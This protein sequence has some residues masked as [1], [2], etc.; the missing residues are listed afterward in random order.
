MQVS[1][2]AYHFALSIFPSLYFALEPCVRVASARDQYTVSYL[3]IRPPFWASLPDDPNFYPSSHNSNIIPSLI[4]LDIMSSCCCS[5]VRT[6]YTPTV[7]FKE[8]PCTIYTLTEAHK[9]LIQL[10]RCSSCSHRLIGPDPRALHLFNFNNRI[11]LTHELLDEYTSAYTSSET[12]FVAWVTVLSR[13]Y[14]QRQS[15]RPFLS[16]DLFRTI[17]FAYVRLQHLESKDDCPECGPIPNDTIWDGITLAFSQK[18][19]LPSLCPPTMPNS[20][21]LQRTNVRYYSAQQLVADVKLRKAVRKVIMSRSLI[22]NNGDTS[23]D[24]ELEGC[25]SPEKAAD[26][27]LARIDLIPDVCARLSK[28]DKSLGN[29]F[30]SHFGIRALSAGR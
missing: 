16:V 20:K 23:N 13:R 7:A 14:Q 27:L 15:R 8:Y 6:M 4:P 11:L 18:H 12:P 28:V 1:S 3:P 19:L 9:S 30:I 26:E 22:L 5:N 29:V 24:E 21:S 2:G 10:Q 17:W 25:N